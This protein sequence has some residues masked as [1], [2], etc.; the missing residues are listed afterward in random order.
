MQQF[1]KI[2]L[3]FIVFGFLLNCIKVA[4]PLGSFDFYFLEY[5]DDRKFFMFIAQIIWYF[6]FHSDFFLFEFL[7]YLN[8]F[9]FISYCFFADLHSCLLQAGL[10]FMIGI[11]SQQVQVLF[12]WNFLFRDVILFRTC[13]KESRSNLFFVK[14]FITAIDVNLFK[15]SLWSKPII[16]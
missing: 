16:K 7:N 4:L 2:S 3:N 1:W 12:P 9:L 14:I 15:F 6:C 10:S 13:D 5:A 8:Y 11:N